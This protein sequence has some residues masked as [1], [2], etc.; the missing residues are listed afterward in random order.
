M[1]RL[2]ELAVPTMAWVVFNSMSSFVSVDWKFVPLTVTAVP[3]FPILGVKLLIVGTVE[4][5][6]VKAELLLAEPL[7]DTT[8]TVPLVAPDGTDVT[9]WVAVEDD[10]A[11]LV[12][13]NVTVFWL[14]VALN[15]V[16]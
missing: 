15:A 13:L 9:I 10:T 3:G 1:L 5:L 6:T 4:L 8:V 7:G 16:P 12:P 11:A 2:L 14:G